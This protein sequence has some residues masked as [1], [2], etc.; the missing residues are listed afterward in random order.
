MLEY[1]FDYITGDARAAEL[2]LISGTISGKIGEL[3]ILLNQSFHFTGVNGDID[4]RLQQEEIDILEQLYLR[5]YNT[6]QSQKLLRGLY[7]TNTTASV[8]EDSSPWIELTEGD[9]T[10]KKSPGSSGGSASSRLNMSKDFKALSEEARKKIEQLVYMY[11]MYGSVPREASANECGESCGC[12]ESDLTSSSDT[13]SSDANE[14]DQGAETTEENNTTESSDPAPEP[15]GDGTDQ[16]SNTE[17]DNTGSEVGS[18]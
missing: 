10:I 5:D 4:P 17:G 13:T 1:E 3:N 18:E 16:N 7:D 9:T 11:N 6:K 12:K 14:S 15:E 8:T 2:L